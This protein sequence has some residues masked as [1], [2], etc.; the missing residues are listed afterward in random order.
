MAVGYREK[1]IKIRLPEALIV[2]ISASGYFL[3][4]YYWGIGSIKCE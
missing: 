1:K 3:K 4:Y 2:V